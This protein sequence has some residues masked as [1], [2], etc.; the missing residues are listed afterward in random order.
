MTVAKAQQFPNVFLTRPDGSS[1]E[2]YD[3]WKKE[4]CLLV[5]MKQPHPDVQS[6]VS[7]FQDQARLFEWLNTRLIVVF[8]K[9]DVIPSPWPAPGYPACL[10][11]DTLPQGVDWDQAYVISKNRTVMELYLDPRELS[12]GRLERDL[13]YWEAGHCMP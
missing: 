3:L 2:L 12:V 10:Y 4:H 9:R 1:L 7:L 6:F 5:L 11:S 13:L 8:P